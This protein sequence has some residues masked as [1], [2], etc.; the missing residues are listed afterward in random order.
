MTGLTELERVSGVVV[1]R[2]DR[3]VA[4]LADPGETPLDAL[5]Q[6]MLPALCRPPCLVSFSGGLDSSFVLAVAARAAQR[7]GL[8]PPIPCTWRF[9]DAPRA[10][11]SA[12]Q[13]RVL[14]ALRLP[15]WVLLHADD[16]LDLVGPVAQRTLLQHRVFHPANLHLHLPIVERAAGGSLLTGVGGD[17]LL[18]GWRGASQRGLRG[19]LRDAVPGPVR[20]RVR[21]HRGDDMFPWL[22]RPVSRHVVSNLLRERAAEPHRFHRRVVWHTTR[23]DLTST[24]AGLERMGAGSDVL[25]VSPLIDAGFVTA[26]ALTVRD[27]RGQPPR[28]DLLTELAAD[29]LPSVITAPRAK[30]RFLEVFRLSAVDGADALPPSLDLYLELAERLRYGSMREIYRSFLSSTGIDMRRP[31]AWGQFLFAGYKSASAPFAKRGR[32]PGSSRPG[33]PPARRRGR[34]RRTASRR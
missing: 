15:D 32:P 30:A 31:G 10:D 6:A 11:E 2:V 18:S 33:P 28:A 27:R 22:N 3:S 34:S 17:Q 4:R 25:V 16:D 21:Q 13:D 23:R 9:V 5:E 24:V 29:A 7:H 8:P 12:W 14:E 1:G 20:S 19:R 26:L